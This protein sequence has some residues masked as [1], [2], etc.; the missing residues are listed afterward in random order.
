MS[1]KTYVVNRLV[2]SN[3][4]NINDFFEVEFDPPLWFPATSTPGAQLAIQWSHTAVCLCPMGDGPPRAVIHRAERLKGSKGICYGNHP[5]LIFDHM[6]SFD[7]LMKH[8][9]YEEFEQ[10]QEAHNPFTSRAWEIW[11][12]G[13]SSWILTHDEKLALEVFNELGD[14]NVKE[15]AEV[16][17][18]FEHVLEPGEVL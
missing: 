1:N 5:A 13:A 3:A 8:L 10:E 17:L 18:S 2:T 15:Y 11:P 16:P 14:G 9:G 12:K 4:D 7:H 6:Y